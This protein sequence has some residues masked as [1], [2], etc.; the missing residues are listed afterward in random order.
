MPADT[1]IRAEVYRSLGV[2]LTS[3]REGDAEYIEVQAQGGRVD[4]ER[5]GGGTATLARRGSEAHR[6]R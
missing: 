3:R 6:G 2:T 1:A 5:V 4:V